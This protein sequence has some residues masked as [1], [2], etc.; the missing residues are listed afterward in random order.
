MGRFDVCC[1]AKGSPPNFGGKPFLL[2]KEGG[3]E[4]RYIIV[5]PDFEMIKHHI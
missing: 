2:L 4:K 3:I 5:F 1:N